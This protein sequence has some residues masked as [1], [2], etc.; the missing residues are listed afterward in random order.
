[1]ASRYTFCKC[2]ARLYWCVLHLCE[3]TTWNC[4]VLYLLKTF[5]CLSTKLLLAVMLKEFIM[6][7][8]SVGN[9]L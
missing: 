9:D 1:M 2:R 6:K 7:T 8:F 3:Q 5:L 4:A